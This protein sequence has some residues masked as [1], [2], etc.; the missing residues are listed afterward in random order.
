[1]I[2]HD[3]QNS[4]ECNKLTGF[5][6]EQRN[7]SFDHGIGLDSANTRVTKPGINTPSPYKAFES[8]DPHV[9]YREPIQEQDEPD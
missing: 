4:S 2:V 8:T 3:E 6:M 1:M 5:G 9:L 7:S